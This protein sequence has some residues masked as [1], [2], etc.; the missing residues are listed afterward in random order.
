[1]NRTKASFCPVQRLSF[2][3]L[4]ESLFSFGPILL[5]TPQS[6][7]LFGANFLGAAS[8]QDTF[9]GFQRLSPPPVFPRPPTPGLEF[10]RLRATLVG[11][12]RW[13]QAPRR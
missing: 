4:L 8:F 3:C 2:A 13:L 10:E 6:V 11:R 5:A 7:Q 9:S 1:M 12:V